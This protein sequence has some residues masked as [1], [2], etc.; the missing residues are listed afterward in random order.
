MPIESASFISQ[1]NS[2]YP[3]GTDDLDTADDHLRLI[4]GVLDTQFPNFTAAAVTTTVA[5]LNLLA[6]YVGSTLPDFAVVGVWTK[7]QYFSTATLTDATNISWNLDDAQNAT[8]T[9]AGNRTLDNPTNMKNGGQYTLIVKQDATGSR[10]L[11]F[12]SAYKWAAGTAPTLTTTANGIDILS[13]ISDGS[14][15]YGSFLKGFA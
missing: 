14:S 5:E 4:K 9:L 6:G 8:V 15:M 11:S 10:T 2:S 12:G 3:L 1:L 7:Q 13:F